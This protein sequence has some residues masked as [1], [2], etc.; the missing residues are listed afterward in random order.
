M[1]SVLRYFGEIQPRPAPPRSAVPEVE[2]GADGVVEIEDSVSVPR[3]YSMYHAPSLSSPSYE[4]SA[5]L[6][7][8]LAGGKASRLYHDL[9]YEQRVAADVHAHVWPL[10][11]VGMLWVVATARPGVSAA[12]LQ[13]ALDET[14]ARIANEEPGAD[15]VDG[16]R[17]RA[18]RQ[19]L[20]RLESVGGRADAL[21]HAAVLRGDPAYVNSVLRRYAAVSA[22]QVAA[23]AAGLLG[24]DRRTTV[25]V[26]PREREA[27]TETGSEAGS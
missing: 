13:S 11:C 6:A 1:Q 8:L 12:S 4:T 10:E 14:V 18:Q 9:V 26:V 7:S 25:H 19:W 16:A 17:A 22:P 21:A 5:L 27:T 20:L 15:E 2:R 23:L 24:D 3:V